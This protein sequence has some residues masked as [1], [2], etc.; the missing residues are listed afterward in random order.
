MMS[1][2]GIVAPVCAGETPCDCT[3]VYAKK[4]AASTATIANAEACLF[5]VG[6]CV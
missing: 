3:N 2:G 6:G 5:T 1:V 4:V